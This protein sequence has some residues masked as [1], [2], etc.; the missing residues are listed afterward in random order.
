[1]TSM[2]FLRIARKVCAGL[3]AAHDRGLVHRDIK[4]ANIWLE[5]PR[6]RVKILDFGL[7]RVTEGSKQLTHSGVVE[8]ARRAVVTR[9]SA[10]SIPAAGAPPDRS[11]PWSKWR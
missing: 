5:Q 1:M 8:L 9:E 3:A 11:P 7:A 6:G 2:P 4:P 10:G